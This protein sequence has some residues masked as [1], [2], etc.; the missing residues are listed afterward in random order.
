[1]VRSFS[2]GKK[3]REAEIEEEIRTI[4]EEKLSDVEAIS[5]KNDEAEGEIE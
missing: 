5:E 2:F 4:L 1:M 3:K